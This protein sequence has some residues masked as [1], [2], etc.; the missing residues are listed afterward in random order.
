MPTT[1]GV[2]TTK[3]DREDRRAKHSRLEI[4]RKKGDFPA[5]AA[6]TSSSDDSEI[7]IAAKQMGRTIINQHT[8]LIRPSRLREILTDPS[9]HHTRRNKANAFKH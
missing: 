9:A 8:I 4:N 5:K 7:A 1:Q 2:Q 3:K 6:N